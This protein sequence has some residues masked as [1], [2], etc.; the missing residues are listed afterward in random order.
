MI[1]FMYL[2]GCVAFV[3]MINHQRYKRHEPLLVRFLLETLLLCSLMSAIS[4]LSTP[5]KSSG[6]A[7]YFFFS[8]LSYSLSL[9]ASIILYRLSPNHPLARFPG[10]TLACSSKW[11]MVH[12]IL[13]KGGRHRKLLELHNTHGAWVRVGPN[14]LSVNIPGAIK[15]I[16]GQLSRGPFYEGTPAKAD[17]LITVTDRRIHS[18]RRQAWSKAVTGEVMRSF[19]PLVEARV[20]QLLNIFHS[21]ANQKLPIDVDHWI[22]LFF[23]DS[24]G[25][26]GFSGGFETMAAGKDTEKWLE[27]LATGVI[28][29]SC[30]GQVPWLRDLFRF[31]PQTGPIQSFQGFTQAKVDEIQ[32]TAVKRQDILSILLNESNP[33]LT[34]DEAAADAS[35]IVVA[36]TDTS[37]QTVITLLRHVTTNSD[38]AHRLQNEISNAAS[39]GI[40]DIETVLKLPYL[41]ACVQEALRIVP[42]GPFGPPRSTGPSGAFICGEWVPPGTTVHVPVYAMHRDPSFF[43]VYADQYIPERWIEDERRLNPNLEPFD[44]SAFMPFSYG[45]GSCIGKHLALQNI[46]ILVALIMH[47]FEI[48]PENKFNGT[49][50]D[51]SYQEYG[52]WKHVPL[53]IMMTSKRNDF[54]IEQNA[55]G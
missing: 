21:H 47:S 1:A 46:K 54:S 55:E 10:P 45:Y 11:W 41:D 8:V 9:G 34:L 27:T 24:M 30:M 29:V 44:I 42:P 4:S 19:I 39:D 26:M 5:G 48:S 32:K 20:A 22:N 38:C 36:A 25:D 28:F 3:A 18:R 43:G 37:V 40:I 2:A 14:E 7:L 50:F 12:R 16:Y 23:M 53:R 33:S 49:V 52:L 35:L 51:G 17:T 31:L 6:L 15:T 13:V